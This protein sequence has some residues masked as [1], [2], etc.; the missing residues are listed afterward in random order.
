MKPQSTI[1][2]RIVRRFRRTAPAP[3]RAAAGQPTAQGALYLVV[4]AE[5][6]LRQLAFAPKQWWEE[7]KPRV[8]AA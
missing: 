1:P 7:V 2:A 8:A 5:V 4:T 6:W 3:A